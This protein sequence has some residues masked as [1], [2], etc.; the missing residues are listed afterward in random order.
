M[1]SQVKVTGLNSPNHSNDRKMRKLARRWRSKL[2]PNAKEWR[3]RFSRRR[4]GRLQFAAVIGRECVGK[5]SEP[6][7]SQGHLGFLGNGVMDFA[8]KN[9]LQD[10]KFTF[11]IVSLDS[12]KPRLMR[13]QQD[14]GPNRYI[15]EGNVA[16]YL[17]I[18]KEN[19]WPTGRL[20]TAPAYCG[21]IRRAG[22]V[23]QCGIV[24]RSILQP[25]SPFF[26]GDVRKPPHNGYDS[27]ETAAGRHRAYRGRGSDCGR[28]SSCYS[29]CR[30]PMLRPPESDRRRK[31]IHQQAY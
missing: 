20:Y 8:M 22:R 31:R 25:T 3:F 19:N 12:R 27:G 14:A 9:L 1:M 7:S 13:R 15:C 18:L 21:L 4:L 23:R 17:K 28:R 16:R 6:L 26:N 24:C 30:C 10:Y 5:A 2:H 29:L 11:G